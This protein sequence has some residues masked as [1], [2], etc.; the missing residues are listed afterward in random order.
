[1]VA[2]LDLRKDK[3]FVQKSLLLEMG[4][5]NRIYPATRGMAMHAER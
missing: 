1:M 3:A 5:A 2:L 4:F